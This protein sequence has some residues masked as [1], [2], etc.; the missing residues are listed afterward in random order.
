MIANIIVTATSIPTINAIMARVI[1]LWSSLL[2]AWIDCVGNAAG[3][4]AIGVVMT[5]DGAALVG[6]VVGYSAG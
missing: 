5:D 4:G 6:D 3:D 2:T 1:S